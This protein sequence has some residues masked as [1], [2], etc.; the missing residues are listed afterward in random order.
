MTK[1]K[2][3]KKITNTQ[4]N[5]SKVEINLNKSPQII[6]YLYRSYSTNRSYITHQYT[7]KKY[8]NY[9]NYYINKCII[10]S[11]INKKI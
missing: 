3:R 1:L 6:S 9:K 8:N 7:Y 10:K 5:N 11:N 2:T 4:N